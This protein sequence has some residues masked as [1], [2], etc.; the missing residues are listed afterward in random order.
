MNLDNLVPR[1]GG[2][3]RAPTRPLV[4]EPVATFTRRT[5]STRTRSGARTD[6][7]SAAAATAEPVR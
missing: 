7:R 4:S 2:S 3:L 5:P 6:R 1:S